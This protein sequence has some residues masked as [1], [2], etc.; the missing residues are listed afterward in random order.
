VGAVGF[1]PG[2]D[3]AI[4]VVFLGPD[5]GATA[6]AG[7]FAFYNPNLIY[8]EPGKMKTKITYRWF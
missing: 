8:E 2:L 4:A 3:G 7:F 6:A 1:A 5:E